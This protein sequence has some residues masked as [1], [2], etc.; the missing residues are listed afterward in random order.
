MRIQ[1]HGSLR[2]ELIEYPA[3]C[4][5]IKLPVDLELRKQYWRDLHQSQ[6]DHRRALLIASLRQSQLPDRRLRRPYD[7]RCRIAEC[8]VKVQNCYL[9]HFVSVLSLICKDGKILGFL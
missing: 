4:R 5:R 7:Q 9:Y 3:V 2:I 6:P 8:S 1:L